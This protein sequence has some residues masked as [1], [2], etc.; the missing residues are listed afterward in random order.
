MEYARC[1]LLTSLTARGVVSEYDEYCFGAL[2]TLGRIAAK[3]VA[4]DADFVLALGTS[5]T[6]IETFNFTLF[7]DAEIVQVSLAEGELARQYSVDQAVFADPTAFTRE[8]EQSLREKTDGPLPEP[9]EMDEYN[10]EFRDELEAVTNPDDDAL[11]DTDAGLV[12]PYVPLT[13][14]TKEK[15]PDDIICSASG[16]NTLWSSLI[17]I[18]NAGTFLKSVGL[19]TMGFA[20]PAGLGAQTGDDAVT[21]YVVIG[22]GDFSMVAQELETCVRE[23]LPLVVVVFNDEQLSSIKQHQQDS[24]GERYLGVDY[25]DVDFA[26]VAEGFGATGIRVESGDEFA[27]ALHTASDVDGPAV[28]D[29]KTD[30][31]IEAPS[32][33]YET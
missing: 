28:I 8:F 18:T 31:S 30:P 10:R 6:D 27:T 20:F 3:S 14:I 22:D 7:E 2:G 5:L 19:G 21:V 1:P 11:E 26:T 23:D 4:D 13:R 15:D 29:T 32:L 17:P 12:N 24:Y 25:T 33:Y 16:K 9:P